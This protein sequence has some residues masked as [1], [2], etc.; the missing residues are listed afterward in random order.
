V[1]GAGMSIGYVQRLLGHHELATTQSYVQIC[2]DELKKVMD[3]AHPRSAMAR[4]EP[5]QGV[6]T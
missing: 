4:D 5:T 6:A 1:V 2:D 3:R